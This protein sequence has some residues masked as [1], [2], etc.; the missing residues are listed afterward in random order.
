MP[1]LNLD[2]D[3][4]DHPKTKRLVGLLGKGAEVLP[5]RLWCACGKY[6]AESGRLIGYST[7]A[8]EATCAWWGRKGEMVDAML[9]VGFIEK[10]DDGFQVHDWPDHAGH[11]AAFKERAVKAAR[12]R[13]ESIRKPRDDVDATSMPQALLKHTSSNANHR[14]YG[15]AKPGGEGWS[16]EGG[17]G[18]KPTAPKAPAVPQGLPLGITPEDWR[19]FR[20]ARKRK[21]S[22]MTPRAE[23][24]IARELCKLE[25]QGED[26]RTC[27][28]Q[29]IRNGWLDVFPVRQRDGPRRQ[30]QGQVV[31]D[32]WEAKRKGQRRGET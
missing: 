30:S 9:E 2:L 26:A 7:Q 11:L 17:S 18:G 22:P 24:L 21:R 25:E 4:F 6:Q 3:F 23:E 29:S 15:S 32:A 27:L 28:L 1:Y 10:T 8:I 13:W 19:D 14:G 5:I 16:R 31:L 12:K 20:E